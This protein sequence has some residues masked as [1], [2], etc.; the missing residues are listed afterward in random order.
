MK[1]LKANIN[2]L[3][4]LAYLEGMSLLLLIFVAVPVK[5]LLNYPIIV[6][7]I[8]PIHGMLFS[9]FVISTLL[10]SLW[11][12]SSWGF[13]TTFKVLVACIIPFGTFYIDY[14]ILRKMNFQS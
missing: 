14:A 11:V 12:W 7:I 5:Y 6:T 1:L 2:L 4:T 10:T 3:R 13:K 9:A 8:G